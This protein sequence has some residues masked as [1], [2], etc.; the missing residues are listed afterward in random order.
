MC[1]TGAA[2]D[3]NHPT[4]HHTPPAPQTPV[5]RVGHCKA[6]NNGFKQQ[7][8]STPPPPKPES[9]RCGGRHNLSGCPC[10]EF[11]CHFGKK[12]GHLAKVCRKEKSK[13]EQTNAVTVTSE[14]TNKGGDQN[15]CHTVPCQDQVGHIELSSRPMATPCP[16]K[17]T[18]DPRSRWS[19]RRHPEG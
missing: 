1:L 5:Y 4:D 12:K 8:K 6:H 9:Y 15:R 11:V 10:K 19:G 18:Q 13:I 14:E 16:W 7:G 3:K 17:S 2:I